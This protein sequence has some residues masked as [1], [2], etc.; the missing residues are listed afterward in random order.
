MDEPSGV[1]ISSDRS[2]KRVVRD[3]GRIE[4]E[5]MHIIHTLPQGTSSKLIFSLYTSGI[6]QVN[7]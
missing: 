7:F 3:L 1:E 2:V 5:F 4:K 6:I